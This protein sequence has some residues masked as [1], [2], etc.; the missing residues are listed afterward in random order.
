L[1]SV[2]KEG[3]KAIENFAGKNDEY[4]DLAWTYHFCDQNGMV[5]LPKMHITTLHKLVL[6]ID[7]FD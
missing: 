4:I 1:E 5:F 3:E 7:D 2:W 6:N